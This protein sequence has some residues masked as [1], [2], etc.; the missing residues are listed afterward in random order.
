MTRHGIPL[1]LTHAALSG[2]AYS[3]SAERS[4][5]QTTVLQVLK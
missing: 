3:L 5:L 2:L 4:V 1:V